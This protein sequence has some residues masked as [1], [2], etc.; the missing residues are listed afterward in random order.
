[1]YPQN[2]SSFPQQSTSSVY[3]LNANNS[4]QRPAQFTKEQ[5]TALISNNQN[6]RPTGSMEMLQKPPILAQNSSDVSFSVPT[7]PAQK[8]SDAPP[9][10]KRRGRPRKE[11]KDK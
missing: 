8:S 3:D 4:H 11:R 5:E 6:M 2:F 10:K 7:G 9:E 1:V